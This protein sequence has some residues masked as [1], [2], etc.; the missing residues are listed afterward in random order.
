[1]TIHWHTNTQK[2]AH[3]GS[4]KGYMLLKTNGS[5]QNPVLGIWRMF[6]DGAILATKVK[7]KDKYHN[8]PLKS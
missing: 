5:T 7:K 8:S 3:A 4:F 1:M 6:L 2:H